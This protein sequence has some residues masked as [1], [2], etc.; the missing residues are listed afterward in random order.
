MHEGTNRYEK[1]NLNLEN[2]NAIQ[3][4]FSYDYQDEHFSF[5]LN[6]FYNYI[7]N[8]IFLSP[9]DNVIEGNPVFE[10]LQ[11]D[12]FLYGGEVGFHF[13]PHR[14]H[15][16]HIES[17]LST[18]VAEDKDKNALPLI[19][20]T[21]INSTIRAEISQK[22]KVQLK[23]VFLQHIYKFKQNR[24]GLFET[25]TDDYNLINIGLSLEIATK[26][27]PIEINTGI[28]NLLNT[29]YIDHLSRFKT[30]EIPNQGIGFF[31]DIKLNYVKEIK[32][33]M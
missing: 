22:G 23:S 32:E 7:Q 20:Q 12:A 4:D 13:H 18:V 2:E 10:Y 31:I 15:W 16:L 24:V 26:N 6:P 17:D 9:T 27:S 1:G 5:S 3:V 8:Y 14:I 28:K 21:K 25:A 29:K 11:T 30:L 33:K 19:P